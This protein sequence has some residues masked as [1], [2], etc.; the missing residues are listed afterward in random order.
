MLTT[1]SRFMELPKEL[2]LQIWN[3]SIEPRLVP[4]NAVSARRSRLQIDSPIQPLLHVCHESRTEALKIYHLTNEP[5]YL[6]ISPKDTV[7]WI[8]YGGPRTFGFDAQRLQRKAAMRYIQHLALS[9]KFWNRITTDPGYENLYCTI[10]MSEDLKRL[11]LVDDDYGY[12]RWSEMKGKTVTLEHT[13]W[14]PLTAQEWKSYPTSEPTTFVGGWADKTKEQLWKG[15]DALRMR[16]NTGLKLP[17]RELPE[18]DFVTVCFTP[19]E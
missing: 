19:E 9:I 6:I 17:V 12:M 15:W 13:G 8:R 7:L 11:T 5:P 2:R 14:R 16:G 10:R 4:Y 1:F 3:I 18:V